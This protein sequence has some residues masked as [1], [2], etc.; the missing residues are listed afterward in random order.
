MLSI[1]LCIISGVLAG[2]LLRNRRF[3][4]YV[5][6]LLSV[7][8]MLLLFFLGVSVGINQQVVNNFAAIGMDALILT[9]GG[10]VGSLLC[11]KLIYQL[12]FK[13]TRE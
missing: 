7:V 11:A 5:G 6:T 1:F 3:V 9:I 8:I 10:T 13:K 2:Y 4:K 12:F